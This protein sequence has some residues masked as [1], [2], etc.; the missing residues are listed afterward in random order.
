MAEKKEDW[1]LVKREYQRCVRIEEQLEWKHEKQNIIFILS[2]SVMSFL[3]GMPSSLTMFYKG[4]FS[5]FSQYS[6]VRLKDWTSTSVSIVVELLHA[7]CLSKST[8]AIQNIVP[9]STP[10]NKRDTEMPKTPSVATLGWGWSHFH[11]PTTSDRCY[12]LII[13]TRLSISKR[14]NYRRG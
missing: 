1:G 12:S 13:E 3:P 8:V 9:Y 4:A 11:L 7:H 6:V 2:T 5:L 14:N 10:G